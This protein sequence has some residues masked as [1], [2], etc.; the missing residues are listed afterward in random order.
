MQERPVETSGHYLSTSHFT[1][2]SCRQI[3]QPEH[4]IELLHREQAASN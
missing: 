1:E 3:E 2:W 4:I